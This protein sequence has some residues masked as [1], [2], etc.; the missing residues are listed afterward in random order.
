MEQNIQVY[1][2]STALLVTKSEDEIK[3]AARKLMHI[4]PGGNH[5]TADQACDLAVFAFLTGLNPFN[6][7]CYYMDKVGVVAGIAGYRTKAMDFLKAEN[8]RTL[9][10]PRLWEEYRPAT[11]EE[12]DFDPDAGDVA[13]VCTLYDSISR[14]QFQQQI[15]KLSTAYKNM[16]ATFQEAHD[17][18]I[19]DVGACPSWSAVGVVHVGEHFSG[20]LWVDNKAVPGQYKPEM[21]DRN[22][23]AKKRAAKGCYRKGFPKLNIPDAEEGE[24][25]DTE[26]TEIKQEMAK[27]LTTEEQEKPRFTEAEIMTSLGYEP[28]PSAPPNGKTAPESAPSTMTIEEA[29]E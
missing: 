29:E 14:E 12:A 20:Q 8:P 4:A 10:T 3:E 25:I 9:L 28:A 21:W 24:I 7:E 2:R 5:L 22:E 11:T 18:A 17:T 26:Y 6:G 27:V 13:W 23:R 15:I 19:K 1:N 16:G